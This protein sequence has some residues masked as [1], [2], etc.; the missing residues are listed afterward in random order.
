MFDRIG[1]VLRKLRRSF[2]GYDVSG[3]GGR[4]P[5]SAMLWAPVSQSLAARSIASKKIGWLIENNP[6]AAAI[7]NGYCTA[8]SGG[9]AVTARSGHPAPAVAADLEDRFSEF[10]ET[11]DVE[12]ICN[13]NALQGRVTRG[14]VGA[15]ESFVHQIVVDDA[16]LKLRLLAPE[17]CDSNITRPSLGLTGDAP[18]DVA[19]I[20]VDHLGRRIGFWILP[21]QPD[22]PWASVALATLIPALDI[23]HVYEPKHPGAVRGFP[24]LSPVAT[25]LLTLDALQDAAVEKVKTSALFCAFVRNLSDAGGIVADASKNMPPSLAMEPGVVRKL[26]AGEDMV[27][28]NTPDMGPVDAV[29]RHMVRVAASGAQVPYELA[30]A[31]YSQ[32]NYSSGRLAAENFRRRVKFVQQTM[33]VGQFLRPVWQRFILLEILSG[34][35]R[36]DDYE[37]APQNYERVEFR[38]SQPEPLDPLKQAKSDVLLLNAKVKS[39]A[40]L[41]A[42]DGRDIAATDRE[43]AA[44]PVAPDLTSSAANIVTQPEEVSANAN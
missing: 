40:E 44:D 15:G 26:E 8:I 5:S 29:L 22:A 31:D 17:Q 10:S 9:D 37:T 1:N 20:R 39:R 28:P 4:W 16:R 14:L 7:V 32:T 35:L 6:T 25:T 34:R 36:A 18:A 19:G 33:I 13:L 21:T 30:S 24:W 2:G 3:S 38:F 23:C 43:I 27:F 41:I 42:R 11:C 12:G